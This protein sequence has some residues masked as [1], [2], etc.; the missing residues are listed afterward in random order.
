[1]RRLAFAIGAALAVSSCINDSHTCTFPPDIQ[2]QLTPAGK[3]TLAG[4][5]TERSCEWGRMAL[6]QVRRHEAHP[7]EPL[8]LAPMTQQLETKWAIEDLECWSGCSRDSLITEHSDFW[9]RD[10]IPTLR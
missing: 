5:T 2:A 6:L 3:A 10:T 9:M 7:E 1:M 8:D 4:F